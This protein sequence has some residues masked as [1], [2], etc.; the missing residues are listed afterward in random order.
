MEVLRTVRADTLAY[1]IE[2]DNREWRAPFA[3][4]CPDLVVAN[5]MSAAPLALAVAA[6]APVVVVDLHEYAPQEHEQN[7]PWRILVA[8]RTGGW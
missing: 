6:G 1:W 2:A 3:D 5:N 4:A 7:L 8:P